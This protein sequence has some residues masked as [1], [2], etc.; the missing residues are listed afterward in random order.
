MEEEAAAAADQAAV[1]EIRGILRMRNSSKSKIFLQ[2]SD[3]LCSSARF[4][5]DLTL[6]KRFCER[7]EGRESE[8]SSRSSRWMVNDL[9]VVLPLAPFSLS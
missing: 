3:H 1:V 8:C 5:S 6:C 4:N 7:K 2:W 9:Q